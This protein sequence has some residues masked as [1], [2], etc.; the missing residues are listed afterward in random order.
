MKFKRLL[1]LLHG[2]TN[3]KQ[4]PIRKRARREVTKSNI[5]AS[6]KKGK[7]NVRHLLSIAVHF[8]ELNEKEIIIGFSHIP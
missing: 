6:L 8:S 3:V 4:T 1:I 7:L 5:Y 2:I